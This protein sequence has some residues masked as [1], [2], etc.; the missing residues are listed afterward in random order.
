MG[1][2]ERSSPVEFCALPRVGGGLLRR[3]P[4]VRFEEFF[5]PEL[6]DALAQ[7]LIAGVEYER[8]ELGGV[9]AQWRARRPL[10]DVYFGPMQRRLGWFT[11]P[12]VSEA[13]AFFESQE[14]VRWLGHLA[15]EDVRFLRPVTAYRLGHGDRICLHDDMSDPDHLVSV[16][17]N[18]SR[19]WSSAYGGSTV[20]GEVTSV[21]PLSTP[22][23]SPIRLQRWEVTDE[24]EFVPSF[25]SL[26]V[27]RLGEQFA[28]G[29]RE[30]TASRS[31]LSLIGIYGR[32]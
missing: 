22:A 6:A 8:V 7:E 24:R 32:R 10:G 20:F 25:N 2:A 11:E 23:D 3:D 28:H 17:Y 4:C 31:R 19:D 27:M 9:T 15:G 1:S 16:A 13:L 29:V 12:E 30:V 26:L 18:L 21:V 5:P 14:F